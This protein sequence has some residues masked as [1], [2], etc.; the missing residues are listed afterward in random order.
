MSSSRRTPG[1][2]SSWCHVTR[3]RSCASPTAA[4][5]R[6]SSASSSAGRSARRRRRSTRVTA[7]S[8]FASSTTRIPGGFVEHHAVRRTARPQAS[9][10][11]RTAC[12]APVL[13][14]W[15]TAL[16][17][18]EHPERDRDVLTR[19]GGDRA[20]MEELVVAE[21]GGT[22]VRAPQRVDDRADRVERPPRATASGRSRRPSRARCTRRSPTQ[23]SDEADQRREHLRRPRP[24]QLQQDRGA[25]RRRRR[26]RAPGSPSR[27]RGR[28]ARTAC[29]CPRSAGRCLRG[30]AARATTVRRGVQVGRW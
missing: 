12:G 2:R 27:A 15:S 24:E 28:A 10:L 14:G 25:P 6:S 5:R 1:R 19:R 9:A 29:T 22:R 20:Q 23:P 21:H 3:R 13:R 30:R 8:R 26:S 7:R 16:A 11:V 17:A 18:R 4:R